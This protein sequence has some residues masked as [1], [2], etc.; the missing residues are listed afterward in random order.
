MADIRLHMLGDE[1]VESTMERISRHVVSLMGVDA[2][3]VVT[4]S[5]SEPLLVADHGLDRVA[6][7]PRPGKDSTIEP[8]V[9][10]ALRSRFVDQSTEERAVIIVRI[11]TER[12]DPAALVLVLRHGEVELAND[13][14]AV[15]DS[16]AAQGA[17]AFEL[18]TA[19][20]DRERLL[21]TGDRE[22][23]A[24]DLHDLVIQRLFGAGMGLQGALPLI[25][26][27]EASTRISTAID[28]LDT[29]I[30]EIR[31]A[32]FALES[33]SKIGTSLRA[34]VLESTVVASRQLGFD[35][36]VRFTGPVDALVSAEM[37]TEVLAVLREALS[38][39]ARHAHARNVAVEVASDDTDLILVVSDDG[40]G[41]GGRTHESGLANMRSRAEGL[42]GSLTLAAGEPSG[43]RLE[44]RVPLEQPA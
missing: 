33:T 41:L 22:R 30:K 44:W 3:A 19:R 11:P 8:M 5:G 24:R 37:T 16:L 12:T 31:S 36:S 2:A 20:A 40:E 23:I 26:N 1:P 13:D 43:T 38:N 21:L 17:L 28:D 9:L 18:T 7:M 14:A 10:E 39:V 35:P 25:A 32:I 27:S 29:T 34:E 15:V 4:F 42:G 6:G